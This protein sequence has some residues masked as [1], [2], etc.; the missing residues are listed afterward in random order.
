MLQSI[1]SRQGIS[2]EEINSLEE[3]HNCTMRV[4]II[5]IIGVLAELYWYAKMAYIGGGFSAGV[6]NVM[7]P[8]VAG[9]PTFF[10]PKYQNFDEAIQ[11]INNEAGFVI[12]KRKRF[13]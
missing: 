12:K 7:E 9:V 13:Y 8:A 3:L 11:I 1:F 6:H 2:S 5:N 10:G 4:K